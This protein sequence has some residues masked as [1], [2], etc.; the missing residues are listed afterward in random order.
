MIESTMPERAATKLGIV[1]ESKAINEL[2][3][4]YT[5]VVLSIDTP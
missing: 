1:R 5:Y 2:I 3:A 4:L